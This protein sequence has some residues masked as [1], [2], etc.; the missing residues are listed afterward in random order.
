LRRM[1][2]QVIAS[3]SLIIAKEKSLDLVK[4]LSQLN[5]QFL[6]FFVKSLD[7]NLLFISQLC[8]MCYNCLF[9]NKGVT[10][11][12][13]SD[14]SFAFKDVLIGKLYLIDFIPKEVELDRCLIAKINMG[15]FWQRRL[16]HVS[17]RNLYKL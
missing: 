13:R 11:F 5:I 2:V 15:W 12:R 1:I 10:V 17:M 9:I 6:K 16:A 3:H 14:G 4:L 7:C 8:E